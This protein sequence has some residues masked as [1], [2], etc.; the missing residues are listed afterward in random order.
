MISNQAWVVCGGCDTWLTG[1]VAK[2]CLQQIVPQIVTI[3][4]RRTNFATAAT[5][6]TATATTTAVFM[7]MLILL[8]FNGLFM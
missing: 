7:L 3:S 4:L 1:I 2:H 5:T 8:E 6:T